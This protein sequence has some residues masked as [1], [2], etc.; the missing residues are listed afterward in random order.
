MSSNQLSI[1]KITN[2][3]YLDGIAKDEN[4]NFYISCWGGATGSIYRYSNDF[5]STPS[6]I[7]TNLGGPA[8]L[9]YREDIRTIILPRMNDNMIDFI[10]IG[11]PPKVSLYLPED[12]AVL[13]DYQVKFQWNSIA[14]VSKY[15]LEISKYE[16]FSSILT[17]EQYNVNYSAVFT[18]DTSTKYYWRVSASNL[19]EWGE[20]SNVWNFTTGT[21]M[22]NPPTLLL[23]ENMA[24]GV[25][26]NPNL[27]WTKSAAAI[28]EVQIASNTQF[29][30]V[31]WSAKD[32][33][34]T[35]IIVV[36][37]LNPNN[38]YYW[39]VRTYS[40]IVTSDWSL[41]SI[42][43][44]YN[45]APAIPELLYPGNFSANIYRTPTFE[46]L[47]VTNALNYDIDVSYNYE[48]TSDSTNHYQK[49]STEDNIQ[50][51]KINDS[52]HYAEQ[53]WWRVRSVN[54]YGQSQWS[55]VY[56]FHTIIE[57]DDTT[58]KSVN[59]LNKYISVGPNPANEYLNIYSSLNLNNPQFEIINE[60]GTVVKRF[61]FISDSNDFR[62][63]LN[64][65][66]LA[67]GLYLLKIIENGQQISIFKFIRQ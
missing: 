16:D 8:D 34:D 27:V 1:L 59:E 49:S 22:F 66:D 13:E 3:N 61:E 53:Y 46:W 35:T 67:S 17:T 5:N 18:L 21:M 14:G 47:S 4:N 64:I 60:L 40:G 51:Y 12:N 10:L 25:S 23:P 28:Y 30:T 39:R 57:G 26:I 31:L 15:K 7:K 2:L 33:T 50:K 45:T 32:L 56:L 11:A 41:P 37:S 19:G 52:L 29:T 65:K 6:I 63:Q 43:Y 38:A 24:T 44:T 48:F 42:F 9:I 20:A 58:T 55:E 36:P 54:D 62:T